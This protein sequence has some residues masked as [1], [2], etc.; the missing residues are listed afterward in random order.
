MLSLLPLLWAP[1][2]REKLLHPC[3]CVVGGGAGMACHWSQRK[4]LSVFLCHFLLYCHETLLFT[5]LKAIYFGYLAGQQA[6]RIHLLLAPSPGLG[7][8]VH[9]TIPRCV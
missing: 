1:I 5:E 2:C 4:T 9:T 7:L 3:E 6:L 8:Q